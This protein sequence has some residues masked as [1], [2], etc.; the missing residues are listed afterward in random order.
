MNDFT[1][2][3]DDGKTKSTELD[4]D[5]ARLRMNDHVGLICKNPGKFC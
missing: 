2:K 1:E 3:V 5:N 4:N